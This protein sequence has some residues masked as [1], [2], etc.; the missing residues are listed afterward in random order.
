MAEVLLQKLY[1]F[2][3][4]GGSTIQDLYQ[5]FLIVGHIELFLVVGYHFL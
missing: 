3:G 4:F 1:V 5:G 2:L